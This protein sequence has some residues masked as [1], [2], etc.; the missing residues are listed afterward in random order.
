ME[1]LWRL[2]ATDI[3]ALIKSKKVSAKE[4][5]TAALARLDAVN[6]AI[7]AVVDH[8]PADVLAQAGAIDAAIARGE[9]AG[10]LAGVPVTVKVN[11]DQ[12]GFATTN[13]LKLQRDIIAKTNSPVIDNLRKAG[14]VILGRTN[15]PAFS[16][17]WF[18]TNLIHGDTKNPRDPGI[19]PGGSSGGAGA[20]VA[21]GIG[22]IAHGTD[23]AG[24]IRYPAYACGVH[25]L[26]PTVGRIAA[27]NASLPERPIGPQ[28]S[29]VS[30]PLART[31]GDLRIALAA[32]S[33]YDARDPWWVPAP[34]QGPA[35]PKRAALCLQPDGL[36]TVAEVK[37]AVADAG[38]R[39]QRAGWIVEEVATPPLRE[40]AELQTKLWLGDGYE[41][42]LDAAER[43][44]DPGAL[45]CLRGNRS[46]VFPFD[47]DALSKALIRRA[48]L[49]REWLRFFE[50]YSVLL[51]PVSGELPFPDHLDRKDDASFARV[52]RAQLTQ[53]AIPFIGLPGLTV[54]TGL[55]GRIPVGVQVV[56][57]RFR[58]D[59]C[60]L[61]G[62]A[63]EAGGTPPSPVDP[64]S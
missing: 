60:L 28:I 44:G 41:A 4:A 23:I 11:I 25:G 16:Y 1:D 24:S 26:R 17:R 34:L 10:A 22:H 19:T 37:A 56:S 32:M 2:P 61:A 3:A 59:L 5:A 27:F 38:K 51:M 6:P 31:I 48:A 57:G 13:G 35:M 39:L 58:E 33:G 45:A 20:A 21:A 8:S 36:E 14:A 53:I 7:N 50:T 42:Q 43:E 63:I 54:S 30:G 9:D 29:A 52:W 55:V 12:E 15:C 47:A 18:T 40:A 62:E 64:A 49:A 46:K